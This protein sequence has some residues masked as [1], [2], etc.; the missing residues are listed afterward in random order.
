MTRADLIAT[1]AFRFPTLTVKDA[2]IAV[3]EILDAI[4]QFRSPKSMCPISLLA[5]NYGNAYKRQS[6]TYRFSKPPDVWTERTSWQ[7]I[8][9]PRAIA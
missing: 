5:R 7:S 2:D 3:K 4:G 6:K 1:I 9:S 8:R